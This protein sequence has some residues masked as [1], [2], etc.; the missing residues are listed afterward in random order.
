MAELIRGWIP[1]VMKREG[2][3]IKDPSVP[4]QKFKRGGK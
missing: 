2:Y 3:E 4:E 1:E